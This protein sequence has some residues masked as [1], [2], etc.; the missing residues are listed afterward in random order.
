[1]SDMKILHINNVAGVPSI[2][3]QGLRER[4][5]KA[6]LLVRK[7][8]PY[9]FPNETVL[10]ASVPMFL[11]KVLKLC[12]DY[13]IVHVHGLS[14]RPFFNA[15]IFCLKAFGAKLVLH[16]H[17]TEIRESHN[18]LSTR[19][20]IEVSSK[21]LVSTPDLMPYCPKAVWLPTPIDPIFRPLD[22]LSRHGKALYFR[23]WYEQGKERVIRMECEKMGLELTIPDR[24]I[25]Y[26]KMPI[27]LNRFE[28]FFDR[29]VIPSLSKTA[30]EAL[31]CG[32][33]VISWKG[34]VTN[35][36]EILRNHSLEAVTE[37]LLKVYE[38]MFCARYKRL[39]NHPT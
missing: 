5:I 6:D 32:C 3:V 9:S 33:K 18:R 30:F 37:K 24:P 34:I 15:N 13:D 27:L 2:L 8:H 20:A 36:E 23:K 4:G 25:S 28:V 39:N 7:R 21:V 12:G 14:Y 11:F 10:H 1:M 16:L 26:R 35:S 22:N 19:A 29:F 31:A 17:G 38:E